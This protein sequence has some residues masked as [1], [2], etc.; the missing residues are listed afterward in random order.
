MLETRA[1]HSQDRVSRGPAPSRTMELLKPYTVEH[2]ARISG[3]PDGAAGSAG[4]ALR[5]SQ[6][7]GHVLVDHGLQPACAWR[8]G[9]P[10]GLQHPSPDRED[11]RAGQQPVLA[12]GGFPSACGTAREVGT[13]SHRLPADMQVT[14]PEHRHHAEERWKLPAGCCPISPA[15]TPCS[16]T[17]AAGRQAQR[18]LDRLQQQPA[19]GSQHQ[20]RDLSATATR[21]TSSP[22][23]TPIPP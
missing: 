2:A 21:R 8:V 11:Q 4:P 15:T 20:Q 3:V 17:D 7:E 18:L 1:A 23:R 5:R 19:D 9:Q 16:R 10:H 12:H 14:N 6:G 13:F 22:S